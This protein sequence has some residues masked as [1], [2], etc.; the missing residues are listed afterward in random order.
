M[1]EALAHGLAGQADARFA[2]L[3]APHRAGLLAHCYRMTGS[4][5]DAEDA[6]QETLLR[7]WQSFD[8]FEG[9][10]SLRT[11]LFT[12]A[13]NAA[14]RQLERQARRV[15]PVDLGPPAGLGDDI[16][17]PLVETAW[18]SPFP[19][20]GMEDVDAT[21][22]GRYESKE[23][24]E[25]AFVAALQHLPSR[26]RAVLLLRDVLA[27]SAQE[28]ADALDSSTA[29]VNSA[30][31]RAHRTMAERL[32]ERSQQA[33]LRSVGDAEV[34]ALVERLVDAWERHD[35]DALVA[36]LTDDVEL[37]DAADGRV[38]PRSRGGRG[39]PA[40]ATVVTGHRAVAG[41]AGRGE[42]AAGLPVL[43]AGG[44]AV[45]G[46]QPRRADA[47]RHPGLRVHGLPG[48]GR[49]RRVRPRGAARLTS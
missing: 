6:L 29:S 23:A 22:A 24:V 1:T 4:L 38:V 25:L 41:R 44:R 33:T 40:A 26:Q 46:P 3:V 48:P 43:P 36:V 7:A 28:T 47:A 12:I 30:L 17:P 8:R 9:R 18:I 49:L 42:R 19:T 31:Q 27:F 35:V 39:V 14:R 11:W 34:R 37:R 45:A 15:M 21:P 32:P 10:S 5:H 16:G 20:Y 2:E 13:T